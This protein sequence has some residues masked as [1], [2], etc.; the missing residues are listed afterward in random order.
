MGKLSTAGD[1]EVPRASYGRNA[2]GKTTIDVF[3]RSK[4]S[5]E[6]V[7]QDGNRTNDRRFAATKLTASQGN[8]FAHLGA[9]DLPAEVTVVNT[10]DEPD[11][12]KVFPLRD[13]VTVKSA[14]YDAAAKTLTV[15]A[16]SSDKKTGSEP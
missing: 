14:V 15:T 16:V 8:Y 7:V 13:V 4:G 1:L 6:I 11:T 2:N 10:T 12:A 9:T 3:A 5:Q